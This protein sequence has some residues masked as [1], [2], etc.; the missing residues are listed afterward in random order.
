MQWTSGLRPCGKHITPCA[1]VSTAG[2]VHPGR[3]TETGPLW[4]CCPVEDEAA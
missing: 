3:Q 2:C 4:I 1:E